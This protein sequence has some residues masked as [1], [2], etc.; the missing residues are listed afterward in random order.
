[1]ALMVRDTSQHPATL[2][3]TLTFLPSLT[4]ASTFALRATG[5]VSQSS[6]FSSTLG[7][8]L[9]ASFFATSSE[10]QSPRVRPYF[11]PAA[12]V[13]IIALSLRLM[14]PVTVASIFFTLYSPS[15]F[16]I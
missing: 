15:D 11:V 1:M 16:W 14:T 2:P 3:V 13:R 8:A 7:A 10:Q 9:G 4:S 6:F 12:V 5:Q